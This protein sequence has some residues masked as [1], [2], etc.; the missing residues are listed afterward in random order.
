MGKNSGTVVFNTDFFSENRLE[1]YM[2]DLDRY[3]YFVVN[4]GLQI[5]VKK[6]R[7]GEYLGV[8]YPELGGKTM[9]D[10][11]ICLVKGLLLD[12]KLYI[13]ELKDDVKKVSE[14]LMKSTKTDSDEEF[15]K[16]FS[17]NTNNLRIVKILET[18]CIIG[19]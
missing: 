1:V 4:E 17:K 10:Y 16:L 19:I 13:Q 11:P 3:E 15:L 8:V 18:S 7:D 6:V 2:H 14:I 12:W 9:M 5:E